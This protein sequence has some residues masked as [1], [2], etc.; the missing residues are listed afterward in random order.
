M[1]YPALRQVQGEISDSMMANIRVNQKVQ[2][3]MQRDYK[4]GKVWKCE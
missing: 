3:W 4:H 2:E 1:P